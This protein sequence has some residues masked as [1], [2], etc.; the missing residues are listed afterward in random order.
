[1][2]RVVFSGPIQNDVIRVVDNGAGTNPRLIVEVQQ[3][4]DA[5]GGRGWTPLNPI[6]REQFEA[7][8]IA[9]HVIT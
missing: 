3:P 6:S 4:P 1:M 8:M 9:A 5:M 2:A 7:L